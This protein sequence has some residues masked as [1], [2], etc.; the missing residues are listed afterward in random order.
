MPRLR[1]G[2]VVGA[3]GQS[4]EPMGVYDPSVTYY[5]RNLVTYNN[6]SYVALKE[7]TGNPPTN[8][9]FWQLNAEGVGGTA[10]DVEYDNS[11]SQIKSTTVQLAIDELNE[12]I[13]ENA[14]SIPEGATYVPSE[15]DG[16]IETVNPSPID[17]D[18]LEGHG[19]DYFAAKTDI[20][21]P[22]ESWDYNVPKEQPVTFAGTYR[23]IATDNAMEIQVYHGDEWRSLMLIDKTTGQFNWLEHMIMKYGSNISFTD[24]SNNILF[25][26]LPDTSL[27]LL[28]QVLINGTWKNIL[29]FNGHSGNVY[30]S[31][32]IVFNNNNS[33]MFLNN[34]NTLALYQLITSSSNN[35]VLQYRNGSTWENAIAITPTGEIRL[36]QTTF[37]Y[38][39]LA[40]RYG[41]PLVFQNSTNTQQ[42]RFIL[43]SGNRIT[44][45]YYSGNE[46]KAAYYISLDGVV[47]F[48]RN[49]DAPNI[50]STTALMETQQEITDQDIK[51][52]ETK[53]QITDL[54]LQVLALSAQVEKN[55][56]TQNNETNITTTTQEVE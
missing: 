50:A 16:E 8:T 38:N 40:L 9:M 49:I 5:K 43:D 24:S 11:K 6:S 34:D 52:I 32:P 42:F 2:K 48:T 31:M 25:R 27:N 35:L 46:W 18:L 20:P 1:I 47:H 22:T 7:T 23:L 10:N 44:L 13:Q 37:M 53:Q 3:E 55:Q 15:S 45:Q 14:S 21:E 19:A 30:Y 54:E 28:I 36:I 56:S 29:S 4:V 33:I 26:I 17:A 39:I 51:D 41:N 12:L